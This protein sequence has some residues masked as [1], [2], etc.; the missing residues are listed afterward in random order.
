MRV[1][2]AR[3]PVLDRQKGAVGLTTSHFSARVT[4]SVLPAHVNSAHVNCLSDFASL[5]LIEPLLRAVQEAGYSSPTPIQ[6][7]AIPPLLDQRDVLGCAQTGTGKTAAFVLPVLQRLLDNASESGRRVPRALIL[8]PTRELASQIGESIRDYA[9]YVGMRHEVIFGGVNIKTQIDRLRRG[10]DIVVATPGRLLDLHDRR[11][12]DLSRIE[13]FILDEADRMLDMGFINDIRRVLKLIPEK[14]QNLLFSATMPDD[15]ARLADTFL[16]RPIRIEV[17]PPAT[18]V[19]RIH[20]EVHFAEKN[21]KT[22]ALRAALTRF[23][24][25]RCI[26]FTRT[27]RGADKLVR[28]L[29]HFQFAA[30]A[31]HGNK[32]QNNRERALAAFKSGEIRILVATD[33]ASRGIDVD[34]VSHVFNYDLPH[35]PDSYVHRIG[36]T[37]RAG[38]DGCALSFCS[39]E[40]IP[41]L[42]DIVKNTQTAIPIVDMQGRPDGTFEVPAG[43]R[44][45]NVRGGARPPQGQR[46][47]GA[48]GG[49]GGGGG[50]SRG[51]RRDGGGSSAG[52]GQSRGPRRE[53]EGG[54]AAGGPSRGPR[55][56]GESGGG[57]GS[58]GQSRGPRREGDSRGKARGPTQSRDAGP[59]MK[60]APRISS[61]PSEGAAGRF[62]RGGK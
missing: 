60:P 31:I 48:G 18:T 59:E 8:S 10:T 15:I 28:E 42:R 26:V 1:W 11:A 43:G 61:P 58:G 21:Q 37:G 33:I 20:Q 4:V 51:P 35:E 12:L 56:E 29:E 9:K 6:A 34:G 32:S 57:A 39:Q 22:D 38:A 44:A 7:Q 53:G 50:Q 2:H 41:L 46:G 13:F 25:Q 3:M 52:G 55:R 27:K 17:T 16:Q 45:G 62:R 14:R 23:D 49:G 40:E 47:R 24:V 30:A 5:G 19:E 54:A 36:R